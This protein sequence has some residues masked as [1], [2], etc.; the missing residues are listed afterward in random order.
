[1]RMQD[2]VIKPKLGLLRLAQE[3]GNVLAGTPQVN[4][5]TWR[6]KD[7]RQQAKCNL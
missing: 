6:P 7:V 1:M 2:S 5:E 4:S 3:I